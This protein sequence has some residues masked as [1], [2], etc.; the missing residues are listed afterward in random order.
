MRLSAA[1][2]SVAGGAMLERE[3]WAA[4]SM[5]SN[6]PVFVAVTAAR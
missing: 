6:G 4:V 1:P 3:P 2:F 5:A